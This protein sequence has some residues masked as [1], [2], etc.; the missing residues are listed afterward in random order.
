MPNQDC[1]IDM[2]LCPEC[3]Q[4]IRHCLGESKLE[5]PFCDT[6]FSLDD[7]AGTAPTASAIPS[8]LKTGI[9]AAS[10]VGATMLGG[11]ACGASDQPEYGAPVPDDAGFN[12]SEPDGDTG[13]DNNSPG[14]DNS[15][16]IQPE[17]G[18]AM[19]ADAGPIGDPPDD[20]DVGVAEDTGDSED[21]GD[22]ED[23]GHTEDV[24]D[25]YANIQPE[26]G[27]AIPEDAGTVDEPDVSDSD[28]DDG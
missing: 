16:N 18:V 14:I 7:V 20:A 26:Y 11:V 13:G 25:N 2:T 4:Y 12:T 22:P 9:M 15:A 1:S 8:G 6:S 28:A 5:C 17:Y 27:V 19:P 3:V 21:A 10:F 24:S 23:A